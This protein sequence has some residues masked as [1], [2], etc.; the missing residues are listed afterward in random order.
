MET[1]EGNPTPKEAS[2]KGSG[3]HDVQQARSGGTVSDLAG[4]N[5]E[6]AQPV[7][8][9]AKKLGHRDVLFCLWLFCLRLFSIAYLPGPAFPL[10]LA[11]PLL[12]LPC[13]PP[14]LHCV[15]VVHL[16][17]LH[18]PAVILTISFLPLIASYLTSQ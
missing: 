2:T 9:V 11:L 6:P 3:D 1:T 15:A 16:L 14:L 17:F 13:P 12:L 10:L 5:D 4:A 7:A 8:G 18:L